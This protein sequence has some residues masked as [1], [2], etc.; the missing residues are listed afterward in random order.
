VNKKDILFNRIHGMREDDFSKTLVIPLLKKMGYEFTDFNGGP[1]EQGKDIIAYKTNDFGEIEIT[2]AQSKMFKSYRTS[3]STQMFNNIVYQLQLCK[4]KKI[5]CSDGIERLP[6]NVLFIT[7]FS[8]DSR[9]LSEQFESIQLPGVKILDQTRLTTL[10][11]KYWPSVF[12]SEPNPLQQALKLDTQEISNTELY[13]ALHIDSKTTYSNYYSDLNFFVGETESRHVFSSVVHIKK[14]TNELYDDDEWQKLKKANHW[15]NE[16]INTSIFCRDIETVEAEYHSK[17]LEYKSPQN[18]KRIQDFNNLRELIATKQSTLA[19]TIESAKSDIMAA[20]VTAKSKLTPVTTDLDEAKHLVDKIETLSRDANGLSEIIGEINLVALL[21]I[22][23]KRIKPQII[24]IGELAEETRSSLIKIASLHTSII[25]EPKYNTPLNDGPVSTTINSNIKDLAAKLHQ[26]N[27]RELTNNEIRF[28]LDKVNTLLRCIDNLTTILKS[29]T[30]TVSLEKSVSLS[31]EL[32]ISAHTI[33]DSGCNIAIYG[34][35][36]AGK[37]TTLYVYAEKLYK[38]KIP[39]EEVLFIPLNRITNKLNKLESEERQKLLK[40]DSNFNLLINSFLLYKDIEA[41][42]E[43]RKLL[44][45]TLSNKTKTTIIIDALDE[46]ADYIDWIIPALAEIPKNIP[47]AQVITSSRN[48]VKFIKDIEF[49][50]ITLLPFSKEQLRR[51]IFGWLADNQ[52]R[53]ELWESIQKNELFEVAKNPLLATIICTLHEN[54]IPVPENEPDVYRKKIELLCGLYDQ[55]KGI[56]RAT[57]EKTFLERCCQKIAYQMHV[58]NQREASL[59]ELKKYLEYSFESRI[60]R[61]VRE[62]VLDDLINTCN[63][64]IKSHE[65]SAYSFGHLRIQESLAAEELERNR[66]IDILDLMTKSWWNGALYL[67]SFKNDIHPLIDDI[68]EKHGNFSRHKTALYIMIN[69]QP[70]HLRTGLRALLSKHE[71]YDTIEGYDEFGFI[72]ND[73]EAPLQISGR[74]YLNW[75]K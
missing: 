19:S 35:A 39:S 57:H 20:L 53:E 1:Y 52:R 23:D 2:V 3:T 24:S 34:E 68:F 26:L 4:A 70:M 13:K 37:S 46:S 62:E 29:D 63:V 38:N 65:E 56:K 22:T 31:S 6:T 21:K 71:S 14:S 69:S 54:R 16:C 45:Q 27:N 17:L 42:A 10:F 5:P 48:C 51:F 47:H 30:L 28:I 32:D 58:R 44:V 61:E 67:Y 40:E 75:M 8:I 12:D 73:Y 59:E 33:F 7:P 11:E 66:S 18:Q 9:H 43:N 15:L 49:L 36:G 60:G 55:S 50:G 72:D 74:D 25:P 64:L 41:S